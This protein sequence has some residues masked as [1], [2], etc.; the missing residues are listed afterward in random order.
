MKDN[1]NLCSL[2]C[3]IIAPKWFHLQPSQG[4]RCSVHGANAVVTT[5]EELPWRTRNLARASEDDRDA[6]D[7]LGYELPK[8]I[9]GWGWWFYVI[10]TW[11]NWDPSWV[12]GHFFHRT[13]TKQS[14]SGST[15]QRHDWR[16]RRRSYLHRT[17]YLAF[18]AVA[19][20][21]KIK[22]QKDKKTWRIWMGTWNLTILEHNHLVGGF[23]PSEKY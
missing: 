23:N 17:W 8:I 11:E 15:K 22:P 10:K 18:I 5:Q 12:G 3:P 9:L 6:S 14:D 1:I 21:W 4:P 13:K 2:C 20:I 16:I 7:G 19:K